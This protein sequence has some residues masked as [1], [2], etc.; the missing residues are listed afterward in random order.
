MKIL[1]WNTNRN[2]NINMYLLSLVQDNKIEMLITAE[3]TS[4]D[5]ELVSLFKQNDIG[6]MPCNTIGCER[7]KMWCNYIDVEAANQQKYYSIQIVNRDIIVCSIHLP[8]DL[9]GEYSDERFAII[10][11]IMA[12][13][14]QLKDSIGTD[15]V[16]IIGDMNEMPYGK[17]CLNAD[18]FHGLPALNITDKATRT[19]NGMEYPKYYNPMWSLMGDYSY[20]PGTYYLNASKLN[21]PVWYMLDQVIIS[22]ELIP[23]FKRESLKIVTSCSFS[24][25]KNENNIPNKHISDHFPIICEI[26]D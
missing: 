14:N 6:L 24:D 10:R 16:I 26:D 20:P 25:F 13:I 15:K 5:K 7:L 12:D 18:G 11:Q 22:K 23:K 19:V 1:F 3:Y 21:S 9:H 17:G 2:P 4:D 8:S